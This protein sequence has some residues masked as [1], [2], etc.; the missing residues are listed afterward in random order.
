MPGTTVIIPTYNRAHLISET[1]SALL[2]QTR[3][4]QE[5]LVVND[6]SEDDTSSVVAAFGDRVTLIDKENSGK[7]DSVNQAIRMSQHDRIWIV[8]DDDLVRVDGHDTLAGLLDANPDAGFAFGRH[9]R[10]RIDANTGTREQLGTG[11]WGDDDPDTFLVSTLEDFFVHDPALLI[12]RDLYDV[13]GLRSI[14]LYSSEDYDMLIRLARVARPVSTQQVIFDQRVHD[15]DRGKKGFEYSSD[16][17]ELNWQREERL[18]FAKLYDELGLEEYLPHSLRSAFEHG[19]AMHRRALIQ[20]GVVF[21]RR[22]LWDQ[23]IAD[24]TAA[25]QILPE[26]PLGAPELAMTRAVSNAKYGCRDL[27]EDIAVTARLQQLKARSAVGSEIVGSIA[28]GLVWRIR[29]SSTQRD[30]SSAAS[31]AGT[32]IAL[33]FGKARS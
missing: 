4:V 8:D 10:F 12:K 24:L 26:T 31:V 14:E 33:K 7:S 19:N 17:R 2:K 28:R 6:G 32:M 5:I 29:E 20:R 16:Q 21:C 1:I 3:P 22:N 13:A 9:D 15:G 11:Y 30:W 23:A 25:A 18:I 27:I